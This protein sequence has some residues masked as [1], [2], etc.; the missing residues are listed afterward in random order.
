[1][2]KEGFFCIH[3]HKRTEDVETKDLRFIEAQK[4]LQIVKVGENVS[5]VK[6]LGEGILLMNQS[7][8]VIGNDLG[9]LRYLYKIPKSIEFCAP[10]VHK[11]VD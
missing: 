3:W 2:G 7:L 9:K 6:H 11:R 10:E 4:D 5:S 1:M 8:K